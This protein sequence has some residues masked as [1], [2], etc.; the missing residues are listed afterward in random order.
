MTK[1][2][3]L[4]MLA[5][6][7]VLA[8]VGWAS[9]ANT[10]WWHEGRPDSGYWERSGPELGG[11]ASYYRSIDNTADN[12]RAYG[13]LDFRWH[14]EHRWALEA[15]GDYR[16]EH[17]SPG[18]DSETYPVLGSIIGY[19]TPQSRI[20]PYGLAGY[21]WYRT[22]TTAPNG[23][24]NDQGRFGPHVGVGLQ[25]FIDKHWSIDGNW[26]YAWPGDI[27]TQDAVAGTGFTARTVNADGWI[28]Q[29]GVKY[30]W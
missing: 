24:K 1:R 7:V 10:D 5:A 12:R 15:T 4:P 19:V 14:F 2:N 16:K 25:G 21:G 8:F 22:H 23:Y 28:A 27:H 20:T 13:G 9:A 17:Y 29:A 18:T 3:A 6:Y 26:R 30:L 11:H